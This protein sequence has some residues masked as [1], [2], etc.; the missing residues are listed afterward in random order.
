MST[1]I[2]F[3]GS[4]SGQASAYK[5]QG[6]T[7][8]KTFSDLIGGEVKKG[9]HTGKTDVI[10]PDGK[11]YS[12]KGGEKK[13]QIFLYAYERIKS[14]KD[15]HLIRDLGGC[16]VQS[17]ESFPEDYHLYDKDKR[18]CLNLIYEYMNENKLDRSIKDLD[19]LSKII[20][21]NNSYFS[22]KIKLQNSNKKLCNV[23]EEKSHLRHFLDKAIFNLE[24]VDRIAIKNK[25]KFIVFD[26]NDVLEIFADNLSVKLSSSGN[27]KTDL[28]IDGQ[29][30]LMVYKSNIVELEVRNDSDKHFRQLRFNMI[31]PKAVNLLVEK[32]EMVG[33]IYPS[34]TFRRLP[35]S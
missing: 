1:V 2:G 32:S 21:H 30:I 29:K 17:L 23:L 20:D 13:W 22:A 35:G 33:D 9:E 4:S 24:E 7:D 10:G 25:D 6:H 26:K 14:D 15:F 16:L 27:R 28:N 5:K 18:D 8:E 3:R 34:V 19:V 31:K 11:T 12:V